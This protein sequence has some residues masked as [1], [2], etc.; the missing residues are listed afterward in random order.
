MPLTRMSGGRLGVKT[1]GGGG[2]HTFHITTP[3]NVNVPHGTSPEDASKV[4]S[5]FGRQARDM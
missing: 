3:V 2:G 4:A 1:S 5:A